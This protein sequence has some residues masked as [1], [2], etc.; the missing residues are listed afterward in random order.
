MTV[1]YAFFQITGG[2]LLRAART[3]GVELD[4]AVEARKAFV[5]RFCGRRQPD[6]LIETF[7]NRLIA[8]RAPAGEPPKGWKP[9]SRKA[10]NRLQGKQK[11]DYIE[12]DRRLKAGREYAEELSKLTL[13]NPDE[14]LKLCNQ[15]TG[16]QLRSTGD[17]RG[18]FAAKGRVIRTISDKWVVAVPVDEKKAR[19]RED[20][21][22]PTPPGTKRLTK[23]QWE[24]LAD[25][26]KKG[27]RAA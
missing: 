2:E 4:A 5:K 9:V 7:T 13:P 1:E 11:H 6:W 12:P 3:Y 16:T 17:G 10:L 25:E 19:G 22:V 23:A 8:I 18:F 14:V 15:P 24:R 27:K 26:Q 21:G 20:R